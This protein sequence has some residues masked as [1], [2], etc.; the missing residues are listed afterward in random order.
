MKIAFTLNGNPVAVEAPA[1]TSLLHLL[2]EHLGLTGTK[3]GCGI[4]QCGSCTVYLDGEPIRSCITPVS[5]AL[6]KQIT[7][8][9]GLSMVTLEEW[10]SDE[11]RYTPCPGDF[12]TVWLYVND[13]VGRSYDEQ[14]DAIAEARPDMDMAIDKCKTEVPELRELTVGHLVACHHAEQIVEPPARRTGRPG[15]NCPI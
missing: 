5:A 7:T 12:C 15:R 8:I 1:G 11:P 13:G 10:P 4:A 6:G 3:Y 2:R 14:G 9:E